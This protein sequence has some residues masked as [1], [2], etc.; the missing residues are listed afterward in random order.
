MTS[1]IIGLTKKQFILS[2]SPFLLLSVF[3]LSVFFIIDNVEAIPSYKVSIVGNFDGEFDHKMINSSGKFRI[4]GDA[5]IF[6]LTGTFE[7]SE[8]QHWNPLTGKYVRSSPNCQKING[9]LVLTETNEKIDLD[10]NGK[11]CSYGLYSFVI[12]T[13]ETTGGEGTYENVS[14]EG[15]ITFVADH[16]TNKV[17]GQL[18]GSLRS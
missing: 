3:L 16:H 18:K 1:K 4:S 6:A 10:F 8:Q 15:N 14:G 2:L 17:S 11:V 5:I 13:F 7:N 9:D 12:G